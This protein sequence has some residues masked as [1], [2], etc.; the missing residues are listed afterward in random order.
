MKSK[1]ITICGKEVKMIYCA[2]T[3]NG[4]EI[5]SGKSIETFV[6]KFGKDDEGNDIIKEPAKATMADFLMLAVA[7]IVAA[8]TKEGTE[9]PITSEDVLYEATPDERN[10]LLTSIVEL[11]NEW[12]GIP[13]IIEGTI[14]EEAEEHQPAEGEKN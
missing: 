12:Y 3:E 11:R 14:R 13:S 8:Y 7:G 10:A 4:Y 6:P 5:M 2:A 9:A 1:K